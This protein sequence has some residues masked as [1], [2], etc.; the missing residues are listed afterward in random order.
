MT[1]CGLIAVVLL[2]YGCLEGSPKQVFSERK[3]DAATGAASTEDSGTEVDASVD[4]AVRSNASDSASFVPDDLVV[5]ALPGGNG[6]FEISAVTLRDAEQGLELYAAVKNSGDVFA[7]SAALSVELYDQDG[8]SIAAGINGLLSQHF[9]QLTDGSGS[10]AACISPGETA[11]T[12]IA[13]FPAG[14]R[15]EDIAAIVYRCPYFALDVTPIDGL[16]VRQLAEVPSSEGTA[17]TGTLIND[18]E[19]AV[20]NP[21]V[22]LF[23]VNEMG[24]PLDMVIATSTVQ[25][26]AGGSWMFQTDPFATLG[27]DVV[28][29][30]AGARAQ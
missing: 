11:M 29:Y 18:F 24:R 7:C 19:L 10:I 22:T 21:S 28:A 13:D 20:D 14:I 27:V 4:S 17:Y 23:S 1:R 9:Y 16:T 6:V 5:M 30:P 25:I 26:P 3:V 2:G 8:Q 12:A 15:V